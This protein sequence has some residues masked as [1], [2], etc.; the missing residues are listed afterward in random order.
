MKIYSV[1]INDRK[2]VLFTSRKKCLTFIKTSIGHDP[3]AAVVP[4][5]NI[6]DPHWVYGEELEAANKGKWKTKEITF[7]GKEGS[8]GYYSNKYFVSELEVM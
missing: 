6:F 1:K 4:S 3:I 8:I 2:T 5:K 7:F